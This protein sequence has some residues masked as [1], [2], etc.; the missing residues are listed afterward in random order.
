LGRKK[1]VENMLG[2]LPLK[3]VTHSLYQNSEMATKLFSG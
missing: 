2:T 3:Q 1:T